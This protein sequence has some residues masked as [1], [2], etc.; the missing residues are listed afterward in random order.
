MWVYHFIK[1]PRSDV[2]HRSYRAVVAR[3]DG[4][5][6]RFTRHR[7]KTNDLDATR[8][9]AYYGADDARFRAAQRRIMAD[10][11]DLAVFGS[12]GMTHLELI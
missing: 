2:S 12:D 1:G 10:A 8:V 6:I 5:G 11:G 7:G 9:A 3:L 4:L